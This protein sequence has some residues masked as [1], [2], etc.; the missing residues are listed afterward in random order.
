M[1]EED[2]RDLKLPAGTVCGLQYQ[3]VILK[4][5]S[6]T[7]SRHTLGAGACRDYGLDKKFFYPFAHEEWFKTLE[8]RSQRAQEL[9]QRCDK[10]KKSDK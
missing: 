6:I 1:S 9:K 8:E 2:L 3:G 10:G 7:V 5:D 4:K